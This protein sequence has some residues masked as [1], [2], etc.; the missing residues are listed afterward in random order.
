MAEDVLFVYVGTLGNL[1]SVSTEEYA[2]LN[3]GGRWTVIIV[4]IKWSN[5]QAFD[6]RRTILGEIWRWYI[7]DLLSHNQ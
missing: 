6:V 3:D 5:L 1:D 2:F 4:H 7:P